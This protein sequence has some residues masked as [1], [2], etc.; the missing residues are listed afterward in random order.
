VPVAES[1]V[2]GAGDPALEQR[3]DQVRSGHDGVE[4]G[5]LVSGC[6]VVGVAAVGQAGEHTG[7]VGVDGGARRNDLAGELDHVQAAAGVG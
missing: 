5:G 1:V 7:A 3:G 2:Q 4:V 6:G